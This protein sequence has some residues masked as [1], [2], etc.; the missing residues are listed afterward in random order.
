MCS[1]QL[2]DPF[3]P[4]PQNEESKHYQRVTAE[5]QHQIVATFV[6]GPLGRA[7]NVQSEEL[8]MMSLKEGL[9]I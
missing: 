8:V 9:E 7:L 4:S 6:V 5:E 2:C 3:C 1:R